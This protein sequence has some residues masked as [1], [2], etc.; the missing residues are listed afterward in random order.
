MAWLT[1]CWQNDT[2]LSTHHCAV[3]LLVEDTQTLNVVLEPCL[4][5][6]VH[7][8]LEHGQETLELY[9]LAG[10]VCMKGDR[11]DS[12]FWAEV[13]ELG[14]FEAPHGQNHCHIFS[15]NNICLP[16]YFRPLYRFCRFTMEQS[17]WQSVQTCY[18]CSTVLVMSLIIEHHRAIFG[19]KDRDLCLHHPHR[20]D[21][22]T[23]F[24]L[25]ILSGNTCDLKTKYTV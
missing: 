19:L 17:T 22:E 25:M 15:I 7:D 18:K 1:Q 20:P 10:H 6:A 14:R 21:Q 16:F 13:D 2:Q 23:G 8:G 24:C 4:V 5:W 9:S 3:A 11:N 12:Q